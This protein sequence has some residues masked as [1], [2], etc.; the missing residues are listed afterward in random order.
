MPVLWK[1]ADAYFGEKEKELLLR[2]LSNGVV[3]SQPEHG[4]TICLV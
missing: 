4:K 1:I 3:E 2:C